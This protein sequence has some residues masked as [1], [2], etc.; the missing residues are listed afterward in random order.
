[1]KSARAGAAVR[2]GAGDL[3]AVDVRDTWRIS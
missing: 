1:V 3:S 2:D